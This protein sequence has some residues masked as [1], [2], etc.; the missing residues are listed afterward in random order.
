[1]LTYYFTQYGAPGD[2]LITIL[3]A[4]VALMPGPVMGATALWITTKR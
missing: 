3:V 4:L 2:S 1:M